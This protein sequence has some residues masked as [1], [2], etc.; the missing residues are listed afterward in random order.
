HPRERLAHV[1]AETRAPVAV[2]SA[3]LAGK[4][5]GGP[6]PLLIDD[7][8]DAIA[9]EP[10][11]PPAVACGLDDLVYVLY[12]SGSTGRPKGACLPHRMLANLVSWHLDA[13][14]PGARVLQFSPIT[15][16]MS[17]YEIFVAWCSG[18][19]LVLG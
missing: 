14:A 11:T 8:W 16:D 13:M 18:G 4:L 6:T 7:E 9:R 1:L 12:P 19:R 10:T 3:P 17:F 15:F 2:T 5:P